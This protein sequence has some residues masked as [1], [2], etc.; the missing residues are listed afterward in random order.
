MKIAAEKA[1]TKLLKYY[2]KITPLY[3][4]AS[5]LDPRINLEYFRNEEW[6]DKYIEDWKSIM[7]EI[8]NGYKPSNAIEISAEETP[9][10]D[11]EYFVSSIYKKRQRVAVADELEW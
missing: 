1:R 2:N 5:A 11:D 10:D 7:K 9:F 4:I 6:E 8:W 3:C